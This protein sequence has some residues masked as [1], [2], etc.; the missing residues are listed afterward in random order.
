[1]G[2]S[3][4]ASGSE[5]HLSHFFEIT[6]LLNEEFYFIHGTD[7]AYSAVYTQKLRETL[8]S[9]NAPDARGGHT[10][11]DWEAAI[12]AVYTDAAEGV[13]ALQ[14]QLGWYRQDRLPIYKEKWP[15]IKEILKEVPS[16]ETLAKYLASVGLQM[17]AF[18]QAYS[19]EKIQNAL[20]YAK[21]LKDRYTVLW[22]YYDL[23]R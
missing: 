7:V 20:F 5:H 18:R 2:N 23:M 16:S 17:E 11:K 8:L 9:L 13:I 3:R 19:R 22:L 1:V 15:E 4:P 14:E 21:D 6:G 10:R 12:H